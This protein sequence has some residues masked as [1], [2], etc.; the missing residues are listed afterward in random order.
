M[1][2]PLASQKMFRPANFYYI[3]ANLDLR[4]KK[5]IFG[6]NEIQSI[7]SNFNKQFSDADLVLTYLFST[8]NRE[9]FFKLQFLPSNVL[10]L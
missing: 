5:K 9:K 6:T 8:V 4:N 7:Q 3:Q 2:T 1:A 10:Q